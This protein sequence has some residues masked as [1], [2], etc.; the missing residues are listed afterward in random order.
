M[1]RVILTMLTVLAIIYVVPF[2]IYSL[3]TVLTE[4]K[5]PASVSPIQFLLGILVSKTGTAF[6]FVLIFYFSR[7]SWSG[8]LVL[9][10]FTWW[11][12]FVVGEIGNAIGPGYTWTEALAGV[13]SETI[14]LPLSAFV[15]N[16]LLGIA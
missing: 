3:F 11:V 7:N 8:H 12:M 5:P 4:L 6:A 10:A 2:L 1:V 16:K 14:Y 13:I 9:Y 15:M